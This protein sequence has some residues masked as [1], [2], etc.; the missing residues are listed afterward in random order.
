MR[1]NLREIINIPGASVTFD[2]APDLS[3]TAFGSVRGVKAP[4][5]AVGFI[6]NNAGVLDFTA[7]VD[8][9][10][11]CTCA[12]CLKEFDK[13]VHL[14]CQATL[15]EQEHDKDEADKYVLDGDYADVDEIILTDFVLNMDQR[16]LC[17]EDCQG[18]CSTCG[19]DLNNGPCACGAQIDPRLAV[20]GQLLENE[21]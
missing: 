7:E 16:I 15:T 18:L 9:V 13:S 21:T 5:R 10:L 12:R 4:V 3:D 17:R 6:K 11:A 8:A 20:L 1:L 19:A 2:Y 14:R